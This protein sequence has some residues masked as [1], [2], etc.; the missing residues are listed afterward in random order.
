MWPL[1]ALLPGTPPEA[2]KIRP[3]PR[4]K[5]MCR[6][7]LWPPGRRPR[8]KNVRFGDLVPEKCQENPGFI[9]VCLKIV[10]PYTQWLMIIIPTKWLYIIGGISHFQT[11]PYGFNTFTVIPT[12]PWGLLVFVGLID[13]PTR[14]LETNKCNGSLWENHLQDPKHP[15]TLSEHKFLVHNSNASQINPLNTSGW[16]PTKPSPI[17]NLCRGDATGAIGGL[18]EDLVFVNG[19]SDLANHFQENDENWRWNWQFTLE[20]SWWMIKA[21][22]LR[23]LLGYGGWPWLAFT[24][25]CQPHQ[26]VGK[27]NSSEPCEFTR[28]NIPGHGLCF[29]GWCGSWGRQSK[30][31]VSPS[32]GLNLWKL[33]TQSAQDCSESSIPISKCKKCVLGALLEDEVAR[34]CI[35]RE[36]SICT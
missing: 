18:Q 13:K 26:V 31:C 34:D 32:P 30:V 20:V 36:S 2:P 8:S 23:Q 25:S 6:W 28:D 5:S 35:Q 3:P 7:P 14:M 9:W 33:S 17:P 27:C 10:Y 1:T 11:Y 4:A 12:K 24:P 19:I 29:F 22:L 21:S 15:K 16:L